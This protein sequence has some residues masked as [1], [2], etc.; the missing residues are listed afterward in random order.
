MIIL[1]F[2]YR[3]VVFRE[4]WGGLALRFYSLLSRASASRA[5]LERDNREGVE[6]PSD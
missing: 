4:S 3:D 5:M 2:L 6:L 1:V